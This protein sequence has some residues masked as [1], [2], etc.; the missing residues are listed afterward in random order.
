M[1][2]DLWFSLVALGFFGWASVGLGACF[3]GSTTCTNDSDCRSDQRC[4][5]SRC[6]NV[7][8]KEEPPAD[9]APIDREPT[10]P[11]CFKLCEIGEQ[12][13]SGYAVIQE[14]RETRIGCADWQLVSDCRESNQFC[15]GKPECVARRA[16]GEACQSLET[17]QADLA[18]D[19]VNQVGGI[20]RK[21]CTQTSDCG[22][23]QFCRDRFCI[24]RKDFCQAC[25]VG[26]KRCDTDGHI[27]R[28]DRHGDASLNCNIWSFEQQCQGQSICRAGQCEG[29]FAEGEMCDF[30][31]ECLSP[32]RCL[33]QSKR[34]AR[35]CEGSADCTAPQACYPTA[36]ALGDG[37][38]HEARSAPT[39]ESRCVLRIGAF[40]V[41][42]NS[43]FGA[44]DW[45]PFNPGDRFKADPYVMVEIPQ[46]SAKT[47][48]ILID[49]HQGDFEMVL[50]EASFGALS[51]AKVTMLDADS[52]TPFPNADDLIEVFSFA[53]SLE[54]TSQGEQHSF[55]LQQRYASLSFTVSCP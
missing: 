39:S 53:D 41:S 9:G 7:T 25:T 33:R 38:C 5:I 45:Y 1:Q 23:G 49:T 34:C 36:D 44:W 15:E 20:C 47:S 40:Q 27:L 50:P 12:R 14:C 31:M 55:T 42:E 28:C 4:H 10:D 13:C 37:L 17:C 46:M 21:T 2:R 24:D 35:V 26:E 8:A 22:A 30:D 51:K 6:T 3:F 18:C 52:S 43:S 32:L 48:R 29:R 11:P 19:K 16:A 54:W